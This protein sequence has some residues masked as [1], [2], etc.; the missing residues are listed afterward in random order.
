M[1]L[2]LVLLA[3]GVVGVVGAVAAGAVTGGLAPVAHDRPAPALPPGPLGA[4]DVAGVRF[5]TALRGYRMDEVDA[6]LDRLRE[7]LAARDAL[8]AEATA[9]RAAEPAGEG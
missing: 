5:S 1:S 8:L 3:L 6:V 9:R 4:A 7:E 2:L